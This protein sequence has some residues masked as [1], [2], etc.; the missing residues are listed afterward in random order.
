MQGQLNSPKEMARRL[1][2]LTYVFLFIAFG[3]ELVVTLGRRGVVDMALA[4]AAF[5]SLAFVRY[6]GYRWLEFERLFESFPSGCAMDV[7]PEPVR[8]EVENL[9]SEFHAPGTDWVRRTEI[10]HRLI[11]LEEHQPEIIE[12]YSDDL[13][14]VL[15]A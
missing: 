6:A 7:I 15:A 10:R 12:A 2:F 9:V 8:K 11:E 4:I 13:S 5:C 3:I 1:V 14:Q